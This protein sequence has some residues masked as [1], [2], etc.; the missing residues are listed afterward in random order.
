VGGV[1]TLDEFSSVLPKLILTAVK[2]YMRHAQAYPPTGPVLERPR[3][4]K[5]VADPPTPLERSDG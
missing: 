4:S 5:F 2:Q 3:L 1:P